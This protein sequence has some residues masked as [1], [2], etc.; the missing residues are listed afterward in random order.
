MLDLS[1]SEVN[2]NLDCGSA[3]RQKT[4]V[5]NPDGK[6]VAVNLQFAQVQGTVT[7][8]GD[9]AGNGKLALGHAK[10]GDLEIE[11]CHPVPSARRG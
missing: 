6:E 8:A 4:E 2:A 3:N 7:L 9:I 1:Y 5:Q 10:L 11:D